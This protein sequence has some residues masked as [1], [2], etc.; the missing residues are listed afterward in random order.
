[1]NTDS[2]ALDHYLMTDQPPTCPHCARPV[3]ILE[4]AETSH[5]VCH[6]RACDFNFVLEANNEPKETRFARKC[7][8][9]GRGMNQG[10]MFGDGDEY[11]AT[12][13]AALTI[14]LRRGNK[15]LEEACDDDD[16]F[17]T[18]WDIDEEIR[19]WEGYYTASGEWIDVPA[20]LRD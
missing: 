5:Q 16:G 11:A 4:G 10:W 13:E 7:T 17:W 9:T 1:M 2:K 3:L 19:S 18:E 15:D 20:P 8:I 6:C 14:A 12:E